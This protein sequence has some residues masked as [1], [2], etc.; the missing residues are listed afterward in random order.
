M[1]VGGLKLDL[2]LSQK[3]TKEHI[4]D[5]GNIEEILKFLLSH[6]LLCTL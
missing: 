2:I 5:V 1:C 4:N 6:T 3:I